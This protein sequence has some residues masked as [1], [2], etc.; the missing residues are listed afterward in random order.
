MTAFRTA[1]V[2]LT[3]LF[4][5][6]GCASSPTAP[7]ATPPAAPAT[8]AAPSDTASPS[9][10]VTSSTGPSATSASAAPSP[11]PSPSSSPGVPAAY[12]AGAPYTVALDPS[13]FV[14]T[15]DNPYLP[16]KPGMRWVYRGGDERTEVTV[17][18]ETKTILGIV[19]VVV[20]DQVFT[21]R[22]LTEDTFDW[23]AQDRAGN[24]WYL[25][26]ATEELDHGK[27]TT[28]EGS[29]EAGVDGAQPGVVM[30]AQPQV[31]VP[32]RQEYLQGEAKDLAKVVKLGAKRAVR[33][34][35]YRDVL[36]SEEWTPLEPTILEHKSYAPGVGLISEQPLKGGGD[37]TEL[38]SFRGG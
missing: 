30:P 22:D 2:W 26:E 19:A 35:A 8:S 25:G 31:G 28:T 10:T 9:S 12:V 27:V 24:V 32:Y 4:L 36:I 5:L 29:W 17:L 37:P 16:W 21:G 1:T 13:D 34:G 14:T 23:Y 3:V 38:V 15:I 6:A 11:P 20:H 7:P 33:A 18:P